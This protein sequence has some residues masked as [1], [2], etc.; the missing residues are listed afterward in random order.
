LSVGTGYSGPTV[1]GGRVYLTDRVEKPEEQE[2][3]IC[4][5]AGNGKVIWTNSYASPCGNVSY[6]DGPRASVVINI[7]T[8]C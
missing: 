5:D 1:S 4:V 2:R 8:A 6:T 7:G 3:V